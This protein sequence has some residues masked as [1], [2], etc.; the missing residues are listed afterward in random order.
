MVRV[1]TSS[2]I[3]RE[4][5]SRS[6]Q[7]MD[8]NIGVCC[9]SANHAALRS[10][11][12]NWLAQ[13]QDNVSE[14]SD[15]SMCGRQLKLF[16]WTSIINIQLSLLVKYKADSIIVSLKINLFSLW[17]SWQ[18]AE[19]ALNNNHSLKLNSYWSIFYTTYLIQVLKY[20]AMDDLYRTWDETV[21]L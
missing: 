1:F 13:N 5:K 17:Y 4:L 8:Y 19:L 6:G 12:K 18:I 7:T 11:N 2:V 10:K 21:S 16:Q 15:M 20:L 9:V 3:N 14:W